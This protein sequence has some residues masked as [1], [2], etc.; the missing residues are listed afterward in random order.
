MGSIYERIY[1][2]VRQ[3]PFGQVTT[4]GQIAYLVGPPCDPRQVGWALAALAKVEVDPPVPWQRVV[5]AKGRS[6]VGIEQIELLEKEEV[7]IDCEG[8]IDLDRFGWD[9]P[10][11]EPDATYPNKRIT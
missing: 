1:R 6:S 8:R 2:V 11:S 7:R 9:G 10:E 5:S 4:Y 3:I